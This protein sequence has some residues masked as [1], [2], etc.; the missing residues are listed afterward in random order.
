MIGQVRQETRF[1]EICDI[2]NFFLLLE[3]FDI[4]IFTLIKLG[5]NFISPG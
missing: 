3:I 4:N 2:I 1:I 5:V